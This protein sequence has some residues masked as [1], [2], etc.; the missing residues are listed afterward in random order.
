MYNTR[1]FND[2]LFY[3]LLSILSVAYLLISSA[4]AITYTYDKLHRLT[5]VI[6]E[7]GLNV[8]YGYDAAGNLLSVNLAAQ[9]QF[10]GLISDSQTGSP[11]EGVQVHLGDLITTTNAAGQYHFSDLSLGNYTLTVSKA[12]YITYSQALSLNSTDLNP[13]INLMLSPVSHYFVEGRI[14]DER[15][16]WRGLA[17]AQVVLSLEG[18]AIQTELSQTGGHYR[19][20]NLGIG[21]Y[22]LSVNKNG[23]HTESVVFTLDETQ[24]EKHYDLTL[25]I[26]V[27]YR[28]SG[29]VEDIQGQPVEYASVSYD[30]SSASDYTYTDA[31]G[32]YSFT[33]LAPDDYTLTAYKHAYAFNLDP[34]I[35]VRVDV[36]HP[37]PVQHLNLRPDGIRFQLSAAQE[38][39]TREQTQ[40]CVFSAYHYTNNGN[41]RTN[42]AEIHYGVR[43]LLTGAYIH[44]GQQGIEIAPETTWQD[45]Y[46]IPA[47]YLSTVGTYQCEATAWVY[48]DVFDYSSVFVVTDDNSSP[49]VGCTEQPEQLNVVYLVDISESMEWPF[50]G[51]GDKMTAAREALSALNTHLLSDNAGHRAALIT[52]SS[53]GHIEYVAQVVQHFTDDLT[54]VGDAIEGLVSDQGATGTPLGLQKTLALLSAEGDA[55]YRPVVVWVTDG[56]P[57]IDLQGIGPDPYSLTAL[58]SLRLHDEQGAFYPKETVAQM[59]AYH[60]GS[61]VYLGQVLADTMQ[62]IEQLRS[63]FP[64]VLIYP[65]ALPGDGT[66]DD[67]FSPDLLS[68]AA[69]HTQ[70][71]VFMPTD[72]NA[73]H[74]AMQSLHQHSLCQLEPSVDLS[75]S[76]QA[77]P[78]IYTG[79]QAA[80]QVQIH[81]R[82]PFTAEALV[83]DWPFPSALQFNGSPSWAQC[84]A[85]VI[86]TPPQ[87]APGIYLQWDVLMQGLSVGQF[88][89]Q[90][91]V[92]PAITEIEPLD[93][94][95]TVD[96]EVR[97]PPANICLSDSFNGVFQGWQDITLGNAKAGDWGVG[98]GRLWISGNG[99]NLWTNDHTHFIYQQITGDFRVEVDVLDV[100]ID[101]GGTY[102]KGG[103]L[104]RG[105]MQA[106]RGRDK[107]ILVTY[108]PN[109]VG[110]GGTLNFGY[111]HTSG[112]AGTFLANDVTGISLPIRLAVE[113]VGNTYTVYYS[114]DKGATWVQPTGYKD[115][116]V[117]LYMGDTLYMG[118]GVAAYAYEPM[119]VEF[120]DFGV[121][122]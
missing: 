79:E 94:H 96:I 65:I 55:Q 120:D 81:N 89:T 39:I 57:N 105:D 26:G 58:S 31:Q 113:R 8:S 62:M 118:M 1:F 16:A 68:Y 88:D 114:Q 111:R 109:Y 4:H 110:Q 36:E 84:L 47:Q 17:D 12:N 44:L 15:S 67:S 104:V 73:L 49:P 117:T 82:G 78:Y 33:A 48:E 112:K 87:L 22:N 2:C 14:F 30:S 46:P 23:Y 102:R 101:Q 119:L 43:D 60:T 108:A 45:S 66:H 34:P 106:R 7:T 63:T 42:W 69:W 92:N 116:Q 32:F 29:Y 86:C 6:Y 61:E 40:E 85:G 72:S 70:A 100:P 25:K 99:E 76:I 10:S 54:V 75:L 50:V 35:V 91:A 59:G 90:A 97:E 53:A 64:N 41:S 18:V 28:I 107:R 27:D 121:C 122:Q 38:T 56:L 5:A 9:V 37:Y 3:L 80:Y 83:M 20:E 71:G 13:S 19:F 11:L 74:A 24:V 98:D 52:F 115:G 93:N 95:A 21:Q 77:S 51:G 103:L